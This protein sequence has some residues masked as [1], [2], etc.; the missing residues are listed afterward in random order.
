MLCLVCGGVVD[1]EQRVKVLE[2]VLRDLA[3]HL[4]RFVHDDNRTVSCNN[5]DRLT[6]AE[7]ITLGEDDTSFL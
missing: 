2:R 7:V 5:I 1:G 3:T 6:R 4:L